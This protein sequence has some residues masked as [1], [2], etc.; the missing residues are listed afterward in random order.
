MIEIISLLIWLI[1]MFGFFSLAVATVSLA[2]WVPTQKKDLERVKK[3]VNLKAGDTFYEL[4]CGTARVLF[5][6]AKNS[7]AKFVGYEI[8]F[9]V[10]LVAKFKQWFLGNKNV[11]IKYQNIFS[12]DLS[13]ADYLYVFGLEGRPMRKIQ[14]ALLR[15]AK[16]GAK[17][18]SLVFPIKEWQPVLV[19]KPSEKYM[20]IYVYEVNKHQPATDQ[21]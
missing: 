11:E 8:S 17:L 9:P 2:P 6:L 3:L 1:F 20:A 10:Y 15:S 7:E 19:D 13:Q 21:S 5:Y 18:I 12:A 14:K 4:G 16:D